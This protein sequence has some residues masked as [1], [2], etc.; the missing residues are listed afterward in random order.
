MKR[1]SLFYFSVVLLTLVLITGI[2]AVEVSREDQLCV[3]CHRQ[4]SPALVQEWER[5]RHANQSI[6][7]LSCHEAMEESEG[8]WKHQGALVSVLVTPARCAQCHGDE[9]SQFSRSHHARAGEI[10]ASLDNVLA[11]KAA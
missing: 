4:N 3:D 1:T 8:T 6:G 5:S 2:P 7:C 11:E 10:L 9:Y